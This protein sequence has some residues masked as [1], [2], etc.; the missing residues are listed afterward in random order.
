MRMRRKPWARPELAECSYYIND[1]E[2]FK[3]HWQEQF[4]RRNPIWLDLGCG[5][6]LFLADSA[7]KHPEINFIGVDIKCDIIA[8]AKRNIESA[9]NAE[10]KAINNIKLT[11][12]NIDYIENF[13]EINDNVEKI[14]INFCNP[15]GK[16]KHKKRRLTHT[17]K[18]NSYKSFLHDGGMVFFKTDDTGLYNDS[19]SYFSES[20]YKIIYT[21]DDMTDEN[22]LYSLPVTE[23]E[24]L[25]TSQGIS[26]KLIVARLNKSK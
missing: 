18:L 3:G 2:K 5:K 6:G 26:I 24:K 4:E 9:F 11:E 25:F 7:L 15:W 16:E 1:G 14:F 8:V 10:G 13:F 12:F 21:T 23:H 22:E 17:R 20:G 19:L